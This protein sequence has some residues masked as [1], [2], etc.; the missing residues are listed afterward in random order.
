MF[1]KF[2]IQKKN[3]PKWKRTEKTPTH[4]DEGL[5]YNNGMFQDLS[6]YTT[7][8]NHFISSRYVIPSIATFTWN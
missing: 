6:R 5:R 8:K 3:D 7:D 1:Y 2:E 4:M